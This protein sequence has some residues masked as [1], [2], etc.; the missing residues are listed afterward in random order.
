MARYKRM[1]GYDVAYLTGNDEHGEKLQ[2]AAEAAGVEPAEFVAEKRRQFIEVWKK[3]GIDY[4]HFVYRT[5]PNTS[6]AFSGGGGTL[7]G[8]G[9]CAMFGQFSGSAVQRFSGSQ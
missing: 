5:S 9:G 6:P 1:C 7:G 4:T 3:L 8:L 2:R